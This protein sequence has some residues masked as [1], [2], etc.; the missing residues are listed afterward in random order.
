M[1]F[2]TDFSPD[3]VASFSG[4]LD[5][6]TEDPEERRSMCSCFKAPLNAQLHGGELEWAGSGSWR[7][8]GV[9]VD[10]LSSNMAWTCDTRERGENTW[11]LVTCRERTPRQKCEEFFL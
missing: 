6:D 8:G 9:C 3:A 2:L 11:D 4:R 10:W 5:E 7:P 1:G